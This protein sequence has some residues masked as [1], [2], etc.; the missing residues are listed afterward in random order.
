MMS[1]SQHIPYHSSVI[2]LI[3]KSV[4]TLPFLT[5]LPNK[6][7]VSYSKQKMGQKRFEIFQKST[8][9]EPIL[10]TIIHRPKQVSARCKECVIFSVILAFALIVE[11]KNYQKM[12][13]WI[14]LATLNLIFGQGRPRKNCQNS[15][16]KILLKFPHCPVSINQ[17][18]IWSNGQKIRATVGNI[19]GYYFGPIIVSLEQKSKLVTNVPMWTASLIRFKQNGQL[20][21]T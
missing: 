1:F 4:A 16:K 6:S 17:L 15:P 9:T 3:P 14:I 20:K 11:T 18:T 19:L 5:P 10:F 7:K 8:L 21:A 13:I 2:N 12:S